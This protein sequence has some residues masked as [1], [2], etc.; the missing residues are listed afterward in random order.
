MLETLL[1]F[2]AQRENVLFVIYENGSI[3]AIILINQSK[4]DVTV[5]DGAN[6]DGSNFSSDSRTGWDTPLPLEHEYYADHSY[7]KGK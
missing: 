3:S 6:E 2:D 4:L 7:S 1:D 5:L